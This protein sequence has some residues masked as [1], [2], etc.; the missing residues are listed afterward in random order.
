MSWQDPVEEN[1]A[2]L[3]RFADDITPLLTFPSDYTSEQRQDILDHM[4][5]QRRISR[6]IFRGYLANWRRQLQEG[7]RE[8]R[9]ALRLDAQDEG[10]KFALGVSA[11]H[12]QQ[13]LATLAQQPE[14]TSALSKLGYIAWNEQQYDAAIAYFERVLRGDPKN[15][16][17]Y[18]HLGVN[19]VALEQ[20]DV[21]MAAYREAA[22]LNPTYD[23]LVD[24]SL[25]LVQLLQQAKAHPDN[26]MAHFQL[27]AVYSAD[28]R[29]DRAIAA[30]E[31]VVAL[32]P[33]LPQG[34]VNL[35]LNYE[36]DG[37]YAEALEA[38]R[39]AVALDPAN[40]QARNNAEKLAIQQALE[41]GR[42][43]RLT[44]DDKAVL[45]VNPHSAPS[46]YHLGL[47][48]LRNDE[49]DAAIDALHQAVRLQPDYAAAHL[50][51]GLAYTS[52]GTH[53]KAEVAYQRATVL[54][55]ADPPGL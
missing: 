18:I 55:P 54:N 28:H 13:A 26:A 25:N 6:H 7:T 2:E 43:T 23:E 33:Q 40:T 3:A 44:L 53:H 36:A 37:R 15:A 50:F 30:F 16:A 31:K 34:F 42:P 10:V 17:A 5:R 49:I 20:F 51:L 8:Y 41:A 46:Y 9:K 14:N 22:R 52:L 21:A 45:E 4:A 19:Y 39:Q 32:A 1:L 38:Y 29:S 11:W 12:Q 35:A 24:K 48:Y 47:R 27:G